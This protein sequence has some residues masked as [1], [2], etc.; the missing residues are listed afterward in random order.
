M[1]LNEKVVSHFQK[2]LMREKGVT[3]ERDVS[4]KSENGVNEKETKHQEKEEE[5]E[6]DKTG[7]IKIERKKEKQSRLILINTRLLALE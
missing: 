5:E 7:T 4:V 3:D 2:I 1:L 6:G